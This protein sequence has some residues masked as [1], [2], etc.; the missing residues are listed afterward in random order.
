MHPLLYLILAQQAIIRSVV[1]LLRRRH[2]RLQQFHCMLA[3]NRRRASRRKHA[4]RKSSLVVGRLAQQ[5][6]AT[7]GGRISQCLR[8]LPRRWWVYPHETDFWPKLLCTVWSDEKWIEHLRMPRRLFLLIV[9]QLRPEICR[10]DTRLRSAIPVEKRVAI[11][12]W[13][14]ANQGSY[15][16][17]ATR[18]GVGKS[19][20][21]TIFISVVLAIEKVLLH[22]T[23]YLGD[24]RKIMAGF[25]A[26]GFPQVIGAVDGC[27][28]HIISPV[29]QGGEY[30]NRKDTY[31]MLLQGTVDHTVL[32][33]NVCIG[34]SGTS[35][36][37]F[38]F[39]HSS[40]YQTMRAGLFVP[41][42]PTVTIC[43]KQVGPLLIADAAYGVKNWVMTP[44]K[45][46]LQPRQALYNR[47]LNRARNTV[48]RAFGRLK[49]RWRCL[50]APLELAEENVNSVIVACCVLH[51]LVETGGRILE[52]A[53]SRPRR[54]V[55]NAASLRTANADR[56][57]ADAPDS[58]RGRPRRR[59]GSRRRE[60][61]SSPSSEEEEQEEEEE[62]DPSV[63]GE[64]GEDEAPAVRESPAEEEVEE[65][66][67]IE[68]T[69]EQGMSRRSLFWEF[70]CQGRGKLDRGTLCGHPL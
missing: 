65:A 47:H 54:F 1:A 12:L 51:N 53:P 18:F 59:R 40:I 46:T 33:I 44:F 55:L 61:S 9:E 2:R 68:G 34:W 39:R 29:R 58:D 70:G 41:G 11:A 64:E 20:V 62:E 57:K 56:E 50:T 24:H 30:I 15:G 4:R 14:L 26:M 32:F 52:G 63:L 69:L 17:A 36:D 38:V 16:T 19:T 3:A 66:G 45:G 35:H 42:N 60:P 28:C 23:V 25:E 22:K 31:S 7:V 6:V 5:T 37:G 67:Q 49:A 48:E 21:C 10:E 43:G 27:H 13:I 8:P